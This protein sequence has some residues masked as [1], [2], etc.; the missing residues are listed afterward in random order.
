MF[1]GKAC[2]LFLK[3]S[4]AP[5]FSTTPALKRKLLRSHWDV[6]YVED[7]G[8]KYCIFE[9]IWGYLGRVSWGKNASS[10]EAGYFMAWG[11]LSTG[12]HNGKTH[13]GGWLKHG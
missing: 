8:A 5:S 13:G 11:S 4:V 1:A 9:Y 6:C 12:P 2:S 3:L 7:F 10:L